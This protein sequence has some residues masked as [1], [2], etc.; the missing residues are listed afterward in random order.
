MASSDLF[1]YPEDDILYQLRIRYVHKYGLKPHAFSVTFR[2]CIQCF[3][4]K[5]TELQGQWASILISSVF[6]LYR[7]HDNILDWPG[8][9]RWI[10]HTGLI[11]NW[12]PHLFNYSFN[13]FIVIIRSLVY[14]FVHLIE[15]LVDCS[16]VIRPHISSLTGYSVSKTP[17]VFIFYS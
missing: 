4:R 14:P 12:Q 16:I 7:G 13:Y 5:D 3:T 6:N 9:I 17:D 10:W 2:H 11:K 8:I 1:V 15:L